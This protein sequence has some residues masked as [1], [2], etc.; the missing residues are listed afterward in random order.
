MDHGK[1]PERAETDGHDP[2]IGEALGM[3]ETRGLV[4]MIEAADAMVKTANVVFVGWQKV[5]AGL[6]TAI[7]RGDVGSVKAATDAGAAAARRVGELVGVHVIPRPGDDLDKIFP[8]TAEE[9]ALSSCGLAAR[10]A[11]SR[12]LVA[13]DFAPSSARA[14][15]AGAA[16]VLAHHQQRLLRVLEHVVDL[17]GLGPREDLLAVDEERDRPAAFDGFEQ[18][19]LEARA[20]HVEQSADARDRKPAAAQVGQ[21]HQFEQLH[22]RVAPL[23]EAAGV[24]LV[25]RHRGNEQPARVPPLQLAGAEASQRRHFARAVELLESQL[26]SWPLGGF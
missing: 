23:G 5:D 12:L 20:Q 7:V 19:D 21:H 2:E 13:W 11:P 25:R 18:P 9:V 14:P 24:G 22:R 17:A 1:E 8:I 26:V 6:V 15:R 16:S 10:L 4:G 3:V